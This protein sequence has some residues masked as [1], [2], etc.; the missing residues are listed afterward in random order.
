VF[1]FI[2]SLAIS[3]HFTAMALLAAPK[4]MGPLAQSRTMSPSSSSSDTAGGAGCGS[5]AAALL[6]ALDGLLVPQL[7]DGSGGCGEVHTTKGR[8]VVSVASVGYRLRTD[9]LPLL[10]LQALSDAVEASSVED[11][12]F[13]EELIPRHLIELFYVWVIRLELVT[14]FF[15]GNVQLYL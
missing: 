11:F 4:G 15:D 12:M 2:L 5:V 8:R 7:S 6:E 10:L 9:S 3:S 14:Q 1:V 13:D